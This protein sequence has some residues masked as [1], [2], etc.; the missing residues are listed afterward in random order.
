MSVH[1]I[2]YRL[3]P[4]IIFSKDQRLAPKNK[5]GLYTYIQKLRKFYHAINIFFP[6]AQM[7]ILGFLKLH[8][9]IHIGLHKKLIP[10]T[11]R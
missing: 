10:K 2:F 7:N 9:Y 4:V 6:L 8:M 3:E 11:D 1:D 5:C